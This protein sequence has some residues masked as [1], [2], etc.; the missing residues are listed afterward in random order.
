MSKFCSLMLSSSFKNTSQVHDW[1]IKPMVEYRDRFS[2][3]SIRLN[4]VGKWMH[5]TY[6]WLE[7][8]VT[9]TYKE[10][11]MCNTRWSHRYDENKDGIGKAKCQSKELEKA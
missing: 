4:P 6:G 1:V 11:L 3:T 10:Y 7:L 2:F 9:S 5:R 8:Q